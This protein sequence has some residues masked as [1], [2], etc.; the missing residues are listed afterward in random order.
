MT[1]G[2]NLV[3]EVCKILLLSLQLK[4]ILPFDTLFINKTLTDPK[5]KKMGMLC[6]DT[7]NVSD[8]IKEF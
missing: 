6:E 2:K 4:N 8:L 1:V 5:G 7:V 3:L